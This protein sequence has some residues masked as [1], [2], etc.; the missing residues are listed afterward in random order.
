MNKGLKRGDVTIWVRKLDTHKLPVLSVQIGNEEYKVASFNSETAA[1]WFE[2]ICEE[3]FNGY[4][5]NRTN[6]GDSS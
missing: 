5:I 1:N 2:E 4:A 3:F 6:G